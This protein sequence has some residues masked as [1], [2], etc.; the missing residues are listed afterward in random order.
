MAS[1]QDLG[2]KC[3]ADVVDQALS[4]VR[5]TLLSEHS[6]L[7]AT[8]IPSA[9]S[10][11]PSPGRS[12]GKSAVKAV[13][14]DC[15]P[16]FVRVCEAST[17]TSVSCPDGAG[18]ATPSQS[19][20]MLTQR[21]AGVSVQSAGMIATDHEEDETADELKRATTDVLSRDAHTEAL[22]QKFL[23][24]SL[25]V[26]MI[27]TLSRVEQVKGRTMKF[28]KL[29]RHQPETVVDSIMAVV[30][31]VNAAVIGASCDTAD[32][33]GW[34]VVDIGFVVFFLF[35]FLVKLW[36]HGC[37]DYFFGKDYLW[38]WFED[39]LLGLSMF[40]VIAAIYFQGEN[41][42]N[43]TSLFRVFRLVRLTKLLRI[44]RLQVVADLVLMINGTIG[45]LRTLFWSF[46]LVSLPLYI[47]ALVLRTTLGEED[48]PG[49]GAEAFSTLQ[50][51][52]FSVF[53]CVVVGDCSTSDGRPIFVL[54][55][56]E[57]GWAYGLI[58]AC[59]VFLMTFGMF[60]VIVAIYVENTVAAA[61]NDEMKKRERR[62]RDG[63][64]FKERSLELALLAYSYKY[65]HHNDEAGVNLD[66]VYG[67]EITREEFQNICGHARFSEVLSDLDV[68][69]EDQMDLF[70]TLDV[71]RGG[72]LDVHE[73]ISGIAKLRGDARKADIVAVLL[74]VR[75]IGS[76]Q[77]SAMAK[78]NKQEH[79][80]ELMQ[81][82]MLTLVQ[83]IGENHGNNG[84][85]VA[86]WTS[87]TLARIEGK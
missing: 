5:K 85:F 79:M 80:I 63:S 82:T 7:V 3:F 13:A 45:G 75:H 84:E 57:F 50:K 28:M 60:N 86:T 26:S 54:V 22:A 4:E 16:D 51:A 44:C 10:R 38:R 73:L 77:V 66:T 62:L 65:G 9:R 67:M 76:L 70:D 17:Q 78:S 34:I 83:S 41:S 48:S 27:K 49:H 40:E 69:P 72:T 39:V 37:F 23:K 30:I 55:V 56:A 21:L 24:K 2:V 33:K 81:Q 20:A 25:S 46:V 29:L 52:F 15:S 8:R 36:I 87:S 47:V 43:N 32:W 12:L 6:R 59:T 18:N 53:R 58:Y 14:N 31:I 71:D 61:K 74:L 35:E 1:E 68:A 11:S 42:L 64:L 19:L